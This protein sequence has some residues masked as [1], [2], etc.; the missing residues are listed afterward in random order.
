MNTTIWISL[1]LIPWYFYTMRLTTQ[2]FKRIRATSKRRSFSSLG[3]FIEG[4]KT[5]RM[6]SSRWFRL[7]RKYSNVIIA[8]CIFRS[9]NHHYVVTK[10]TNPPERSSCLLARFTAERF[11]SVCVHGP[12]CDFIGFYHANR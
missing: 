4:L 11:R 1:F 8:V 10:L 9:T 6:L 2:R 12:R 7:L 5:F 3:T